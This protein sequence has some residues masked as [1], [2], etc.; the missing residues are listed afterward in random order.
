MKVNKNFELFQKCFKEYQQMFGLTGYKVYFKFEPINAGFAD[1]TV[2]QADMVATVRLNSEDKAG[3]R[4]YRSVKQSAKHE[5]LHLLLFRIEDRACNRY[6]RED[7]IYEA[8]EE[9]VFKLEELIDDR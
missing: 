6:T 1:I 7:E 8:V 5:A 3:D 2:N 9:V 4:K